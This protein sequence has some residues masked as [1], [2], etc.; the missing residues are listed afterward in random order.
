MR[1]SRL[2]A[3]GLCLLFAL[4]CS[5]DSTNNG[6]GDGGGKKDRGPKADGG[7]NVG[8]KLAWI[9]EAL[10]L[11][12]AGVHATIA[13]K[14][15]ELGVAYFRTLQNTVQL[16]CDD[17]LGGTKPGYKAAFDLY[18]LHHDGASWQAPV[19]IDQTYGLTK[20]LSV[21]FGASSSQVHVGYLGGALSTVEC[22]SSDAVIATSND[23]GKTWTQRTVDDAGE[24]G[25][26]VGYWMSVA[27]DSKGQVH[28][29]YRDCIFGLY[30]ELGSNK[31]SLLYDGADVVVGR[32]GAGQ[33]ASLAFDPSDQ[34]VIAFYNPAR[35]DAQGGI[36]VAIKK[37]S[38]WSTRQL[39]GG[40]TRERLALGTDGKGTFGVAYYASSEGSLRYQESGADVLGAWSATTVD[41]SLTDNGTFASLAYDAQG[42][43]G[44]SY[45][46]CGS[47]GS[48]ACEAGK[49]ALMFAVR[50]GGVWKTYEVDTG[51]DLSCGTYSSFVFDASDEPVI[52]YKCVTYDDQTGQYV[53]T[54]KTAQGVYE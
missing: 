9:K 48:S 26:T 17:P 14:G 7:G 21:T 50:L 20:G 31:A 27:L 13:R 6:G 22:Y 37:G 16:T 38:A 19:K 5:D 44:I 49:D 4:G 36:Q 12:R 54:L 51:G 25:D 10:D 39:D 24:D 30:E 46:R 53:D 3:A 28:S 32:N 43:P 33:F 15:G 23:K 41:T 2:T 29:A 35:T 1:T 34:P 8:K 45:Y 40:T 47:A 42:N 18:Y 52:V 11:Q